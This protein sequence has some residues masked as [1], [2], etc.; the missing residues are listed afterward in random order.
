[1]VEAGGAP[2]P[3]GGECYSGSHPKFAK[4]FQIV[5]SSRPVDVVTPAMKI[6]AYRLQRNPR[7][8]WSGQPC[9]AREVRVIV[10]DAPEFP[11]YWAREFVGQEREAVEV[12]AHGEKFYLDNEDG[13]G[14]RKVTVGK[15]SPQWGHGTLRVAAVL[16]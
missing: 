15:G 16:E 8:Y 5:P 14:W 13:R 6:Q 2:R 11:R 9:A 12:Q 3:G 7:T 1:M 10:A 4:N